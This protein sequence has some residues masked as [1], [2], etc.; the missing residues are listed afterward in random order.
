[1]PES[2]GTVKA[3]TTTSGRGSYA[4]PAFATRVAHDRLRIDVKSPSVHVRSVKS[5]GT[6]SCSSLLC[7]GEVSCSSLHQNGP[8]PHSLASPEQHTIILTNL[9]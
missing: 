7:G 6:L 8:I 1:M 4:H 3:P 5:S 9:S 2:T